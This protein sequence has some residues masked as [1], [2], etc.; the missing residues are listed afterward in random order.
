[1]RVAGFPQREPIQSTRSKSGSMRT[2]SSPAR[3]A[4]A[5]GV[6]IFATAS[7]DS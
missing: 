2:W 3:G 4:G 6:K 5:Q 7:E 1:V